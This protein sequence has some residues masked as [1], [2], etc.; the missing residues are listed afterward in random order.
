MAW[1]CELAQADRALAQRQ[2]PVNSDAVQRNVRSRAL[3]LPF[4]EDVRR[5]SLLTDER[6]SKDSRVVTRRVFPRH[7]CEHEEI[8]FAGNALFELR[9]DDAWQLLANS[10]RH[11]RGQG[12]ADVDRLSGFG[13]G[14]RGG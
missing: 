4:A 13:R 10:E 7:G 2:L 5:E 14:L 3:I 11:G 8:S 12:E 1:D 9:G 6:A